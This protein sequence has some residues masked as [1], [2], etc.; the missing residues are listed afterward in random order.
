MNILFPV[1]DKINK[2]LLLVDFND[3]KNYELKIKD[4]DIKLEE[5]QDRFDIGEIFQN[6]NTDSYELPK[7]LYEMVGLQA[8]LQAKD[9]YK[10]FNRESKNE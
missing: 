8:E 9:F 7:E 3:N 10:D 5:V 2:K 4:G 6:N 1:L